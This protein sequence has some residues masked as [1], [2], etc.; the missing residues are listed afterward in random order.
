M[1]D[2]DKGHG[3]S[4]NVGKIKSTFKKVIDS[5]IKKKRVCRVFFSAEAQKPE[6][7]APRLKSPPPPALSTSGSGTSSSEEDD[8]QVFNIYLS[9]C[10]VNDNVSIFS[11]DP[12]T[13]RKENYHQSVSEASPETF[14]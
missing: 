6:R 2:A 11:V 3:R 7:T 8:Y 12:F 5:T 4:M 9:T 1:N 14:C 13:G 10:S